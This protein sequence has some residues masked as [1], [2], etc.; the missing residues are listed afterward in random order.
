MLTF[1]YLI[2]NKKRTL[3]T[4]SGITLVTILFLCIG[5][6]FSSIREYMIKDIIKNNGNYHVSLKVDNIDKSHIKNIETKENTKYIIYDD[7]RETYKY[8]KEKF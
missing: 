7:I 8:T 6:F 3:I 2:K 5:L 4:I 1:K